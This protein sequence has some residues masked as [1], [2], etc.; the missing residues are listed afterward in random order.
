MVDLI[1]ITI[2]LTSLIDIATGKDVPCVHPVT[3]RPLIVGDLG[4]DT[5]GIRTH[6][7]IGRP[8]K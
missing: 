2:L 1:I 4:E 6:V 5:Y 7:E 3:H 8:C